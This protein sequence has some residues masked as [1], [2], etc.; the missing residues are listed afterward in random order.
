MV[1]NRRYTSMTSKD[2]DVCLNGSLTWTH[3]QRKFNLLNNGGMG[4]DICH[5]LKP[6]FA[7]NGISPSW[8]II[9]MFSVWL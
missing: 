5:L 6:E 3:Y 7:L 1:W 4:S 9:V 8:L 2:Y